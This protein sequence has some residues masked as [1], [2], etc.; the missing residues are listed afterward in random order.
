MDW[1]LISIIIFYII[2]ALFFIKNRKRIE[3]QGI[4]ILYRTKRGLNFLTRLAKHERVWRTFGKLSIFVGFGGIIFILA[5]LTQ[6]A[7]EILTEPA[8]EAGVALAIPGVRVPGSPIFIPFWYGIIALIVV[9]LVHEG[10]HGLVAK[11]HGLK[12]KSAGI[13]LLTFLPLAFV[14][15]D[16]KQLSKAPLKTRLS[17]YGAG[18]MANFVTALIILLVSAAI[19]PVASS[20]F[21]F[22]G[23][24]V[25]EVKEGFPADLAG[26]EVGDNI[27]GVND[28]ASLDVINF[29]K[30]MDKIAP[31]ETVKIDTEEG[32]F[33]V[34]TIPGPENASQAYLGISFVQ[35]K[36]IKED[37][38]ANFGK[39]PWALIYLLQLFNWIFI[40][41]IGIGAINLLP[42]GPIDGGRMLKDTLEE[43]M[44]NK[45]LVRGIV[46]TISL[47]SL[48]LLIINILG[49]YIM[50]NIY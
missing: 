12:I 25:V 33:Y 19:A 35:I 7:I 47:A 5:L 44:K 34:E 32:S 31:G 40:L 39:L 26:L 36:D 27:I 37:V 41:N 43:K 3:R 45:K 9:L 10:C 30:E 1:N 2:V 6:K 15:P 29:S 23:M 20:A 46:R 13:G 24:E 11:A 4:F 38:Y 50:S 49:P 18:P 22:T 48:F 17:V 14:E 21:E 28:K 16:E 8:I 42:L